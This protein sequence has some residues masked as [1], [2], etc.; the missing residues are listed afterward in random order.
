MDSEAIVN[1]STIDYK[2]INKQWSK[3]ALKSE[4]THG[5]Y[6]LI[7]SAKYNVGA[8]TYLINNILGFQ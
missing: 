7:D 5:Q 3:R 1:Y 4:L 2:E 8:G 6:K